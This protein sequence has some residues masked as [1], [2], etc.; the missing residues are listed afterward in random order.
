MPESDVPVVEPA[1]GK[2]VDEVAAG[3]PT[4]EYTRR[5]ALL[6]VREYQREVVESRA[7]FKLLICGRR[8]GKTTVGLVAASQ[9]HGAPTGEE[10]HWRGALD[11]ARIGWIVPSEDHPAATEVWGDLKKALA[12]LAVSTS[13]EQRKILVAGGGS[14]SVWSGYDP[15]ALRGT[16]FDGVV[17][18]ECS[19]QRE[20]VW[21]ALRPALSDYGGWGLL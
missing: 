12:P 19:L 16:Y 15:D 4:I 6:R 1:E 5:V 14:V 13:E 20:G 10:G 7:R 3:S 18:D 17:V 21:A 8:W 9:G 11:G 2:R